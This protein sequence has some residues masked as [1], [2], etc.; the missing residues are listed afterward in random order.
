MSIRLVSSTASYPST[1]L[2]AESPTKHGPS[3]LQAQVVCIWNSQLQPLHKH[4][5]LADYAG[6]LSAAS[7]SCTCCRCCMARPF[8][9]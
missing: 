2:C 9:G 1:S 8:C 5:D 4:H 7:P 6:F 3:H